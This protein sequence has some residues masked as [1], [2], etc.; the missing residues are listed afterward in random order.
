MAAQSEDA[1]KLFFEIL[2]VFCLDLELRLPEKTSKSL[3]SENQMRD[4]PTTP[5]V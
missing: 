1:E 2:L 4:N 5:L 3:T